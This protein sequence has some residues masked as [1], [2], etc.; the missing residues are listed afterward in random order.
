MKYFIRLFSFIFLFSSISFSQWIPQNSNTSQRL[1]TVFFL[2]DHLGWAGGNEGCILKTTNGGINWT[3]ISIGTRYTVHAV[4]FIDSL[5]GWAALYSFN[6][7]RA[8]YIIATT[9]GGAN[10]ILP[11]SN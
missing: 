10:W 7:N 5:K 4:H 3:Y 8:G 2:N 11:I 9:D 1:L 6:P